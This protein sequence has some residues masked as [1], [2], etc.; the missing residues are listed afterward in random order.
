MSREQDDGIRKYPE[1]AASHGL[2]S[3]YEVSET[4]PVGTPETMSPAITPRDHNLATAAAAATDLGPYSPQ[5]SPRKERER[6]GEAFQSQHSSQLLQ[7][8]LQKAA[9]ASAQAGELP[10]VEFSLGSSPAPSP[11]RG[12]AAK[13]HRR[14]HS[15]GGIAAVVRAGSFAPTAASY[16][17]ASSA[18]AAALGLNLDLSGITGGRDGGRDGFG[19]GGLSGLASGSLSMNN[20][21]RGGGIAIGF[22]PRDGVSPSAPTPTF[23]CASASATPRSR[24]RAAARRSGASATAAVSRRL[25]DPEEVNTICHF[26]HLM[27]QVFY[28]S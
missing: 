16:T 17:S 4:P 15:G 22:S 10:L 7:R 12:S 20:T 5:N 14:A 28:L 27:Y 6:S 25:K 2:V 19:V 11:A 1:L 18:S 26:S 3:G 21:P 23:A 13:G 9:V 8:S 24:K